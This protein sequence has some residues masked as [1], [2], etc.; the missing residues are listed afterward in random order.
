MTVSPNDPPPC[1]PEYTPEEWASYHR[2]PCSWCIKELRNS[3]PTI[4]CNAADILR[5]LAWDVV[6][7][8]PA[9]IEGCRDPEEQVRAYC[10]HALVDIGFAVHHR[11]PSALPSLIRAVP[12]LTELLAEASLDVRSLAACALKEIG[13]DAKAAVPAL[14]RLLD[15]PNP[16]MREYA[17]SPMAAINQ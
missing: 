16:D 11:V 15:D 9:L 5:G 17:K 2:D 14:R 4:R 7:A 3:D 8:I 1:P 6:D 13:P 10:A 12:V